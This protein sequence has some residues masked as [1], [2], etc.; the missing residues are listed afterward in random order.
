MTLCFVDNNIILQLAAYNLFEDAI[1]SLN[2]TWTDLRVLN[3]AIHVFRG[4]NIKRR[5]SSETVK[6]AISIVERCQTILRQPTAELELLLKVNG[7][8]EGESAL[9]VA[10]ATE[11]MFWLITGDK[12]CLEALTNES[13]IATIRQRL[14]GRTICLEQI[15][16]KLISVHGCD[17]VQK[18]VL[19]TPDCEKAIKISFGWST[20]A[21]EASILEALNNY[22]NDLQRKSQGLLFNLT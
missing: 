5:Y 16:L 9:I 6:R 19:V 10:T 22:I 13:S 18:R 11:S 4:K 2:I 15:L 20:P 1:N 7:M 8:D 3:T 14:V 12:R 21:D 17:Y